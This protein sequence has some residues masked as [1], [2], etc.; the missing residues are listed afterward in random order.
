MSDPIDTRIRRLAR[1]AGLYA[2]RWRSDGRW[3]MT[4]SDTSF[5]LS[6]ENGMT[7]DDALRWLDDRAREVG[8]LQISTWRTEAEKRRREDQPAAPDL[9]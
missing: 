6:P 2:S 9:E 7:D 1:S 4:D 8:K 5:I 3:R